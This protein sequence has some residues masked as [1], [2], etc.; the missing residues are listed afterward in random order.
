MSNESAKQ[1]PE[2]EAELTYEQSIARLHEIIEKI[3]SG[4]VGLEQSLE[5]YEQGMAMIRR[6]QTIL[7]RAEQKIRRLTVNEQGGLSE[8]QD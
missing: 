7:D 4:E 2:S 3:E 1:P 6:C 8:Q 5:Q